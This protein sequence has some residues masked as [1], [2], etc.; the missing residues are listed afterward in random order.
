MYREIGEWDAGQQRCRKGLGGLVDRKLSMMKGLKFTLDEY[1]NISLSPFLQPGQVPLNS[2]LAFLHFDHCFVPFVLSKLQTAKPNSSLIHSIEV[3]ELNTFTILQDYSACE[4]VLL[5]MHTHPHRW[6]R[7]CNNWKRNTAEFGG[8]AAISEDQGIYSKPQETRALGF[9]D[10][11]S[12]DYTLKMH[13]FTNNNKYFR[14][15]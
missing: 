7:R 9:P 5:S 13:N 8:A 14:R 10:F 2:T 3:H 12:L 1:I 11:D 6:L 4:H 15:L